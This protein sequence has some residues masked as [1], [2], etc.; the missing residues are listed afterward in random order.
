AR[1]HRGDHRGAP[2]G[3]AR[4]SDRAPRPWLPRDAATAG[5]HPVRRG[6]Y[7]AV[8]ARGAGGAD[9]GA[10]PRV[11]QPRAQPHACLGAGRRRL[12]AT[13]GGAMTLSRRDFLALAGIGGAAAALAAA[14]GSSSPPTSPWPVSARGRA[15]P[16]TSGAARTP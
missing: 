8:G 7:A 2:A 6:R 14:V 11:G 12:T 13:R 15:A 5:R 9:R 4:R 3:P 1:R 16:S 10:V